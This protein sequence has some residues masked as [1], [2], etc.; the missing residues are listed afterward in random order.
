[1]EWIANPEIW[2]SLLT[3]TV[4]EI[5]LGIDNIVFISILA[6]KLPKDQQAKA[7]NWGLGLAMFTRILLLFSITWVMSLTAPLFGVLG[8]EISG[9]DLIL[10]AGGL[11]LIYKSTVEIH[12]KLEGE[13]GEK[14]KKVAHSFAGVISQ[15]LLLDIVFSLDSV[16]TA[17][18]MADELWVMITAVVIA[19]GIMM[20]S[21]GPISRFVEKHPTVKM[22]ALSFLV[23]IGV[24]LIAEGLE[25][26]IPKGYIYFAMAFSIMVEVLNLRMKKTTVKPVQLRDKYD[27]SDLNS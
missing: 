11:F 5:V 4:L 17:V 16:I 21:A 22:L 27:K 23:L 12:E 26:H 8:Q 18:G 3:L 15:I 24:S 2:V 7:R 19:V 14:D 1:M 20:F 13:E 10:L 6:G 9:R 25:Q